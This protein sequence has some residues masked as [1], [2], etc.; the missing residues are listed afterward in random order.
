MKQIIGPFEEKSRSEDREPDLAASSLDTEQMGTH[1]T[2]MHI[3]DA[4]IEYIVF[5]VWQ[6]RKI[7]RKWKRESNDVHIYNKFVFIQTAMN[8]TLE[9]IV[10]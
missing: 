2:Y 8:R 10:N 5:C 4:E 7:S 1:K 9:I 3:Y 6:R